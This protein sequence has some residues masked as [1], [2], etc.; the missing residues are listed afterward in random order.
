MTTRISILDGHPY[1]VLLGKMVRGDFFALTPT[2]TH[3]TP[4]SL[5]YHIFP[6]PPFPASPPASVLPASPP[7]CPFVYRPEITYHLGRGL[8]IDLGPST[9]L[10]R[11]QLLLPL[12]VWRC[13]QDYGF[14]HG[15]M[16]TEIRRLRARKED[17]TTTRSGG[18]WFLREA[19][20]RSHRDATEQTTCRQG[21][22][23][24]AL[25]LIKDY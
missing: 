16:D 24:E 17:Y 9:D 8:G 20:G 23:G 21:L 1:H 3:F 15:T 10:E 25:K 11:V 14:C 12:V 7:V 22:V 19:W 18:S 5:H 4:L 2:T 6:I 13:R